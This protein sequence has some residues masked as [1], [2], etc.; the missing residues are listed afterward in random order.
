MSAPVFLAARML[1]TFFVRSHRAGSLLSTMMPG[2]S[3]STRT[4][5]PFASTARA[6]AT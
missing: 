3:A 6:R 5:V 1:N 2:L 4:P